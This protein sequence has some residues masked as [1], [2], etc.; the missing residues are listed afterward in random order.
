ML[1]AIFESIGRAY[2]ENRQEYP[3]YILMSPQTYCNLMD[4]E[5]PEGFD[6]KSFNVEDQTILGIKV[7]FDSISDRLPIG[8]V[9]LLYCH[10]TV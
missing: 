6:N 9:K 3:D 5:T 7:L 1:N 2:A 8:S 10:K 4:Y